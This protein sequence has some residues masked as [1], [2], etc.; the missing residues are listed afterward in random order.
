MSNRGIR[1][2]S[3]LHLEF[4][5]SAERYN[6]FHLPHLDTDSEDVLILAGDIGVAIKHY[7]YVEF[8]EQMSRRFHHVIYIAGNHEY[9]NGALY[10]SFNEIKQCITHLS[11]VSFVENEV[12][13]IDNISF[14]CAT[15]WT[16]FNNGNPLAMLKAL[17]GL[18]DFKLIRVGSHEKPNEH[19]LSPSD[20]LMIHLRSKDF[21]FNS[22]VEEHAN[23]QIAIVVTHHAP[24]FRSIAPQYKGDPLNDAFATDYD[25]LIIETQPKLWIHGHT[26]NSLN[27]MIENTNIVC[28]P[29]GYYPRDLNKQFD[30][31]LRI[32]I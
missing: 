25:D 6:M 3:D 11:N 7:S 14:I 28:N 15:L 4:S 29:R 19:R 12:I 9:Y 17:Q 1:I 10:H 30:P 18:N 8:L 23:N 31:T 32:I 13:R 16:S 21:I 27:Y 20:V 26:H 24:S 22:I 2:V 5:M